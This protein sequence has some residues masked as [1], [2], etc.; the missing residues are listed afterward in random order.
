MSVVSLKRLK[1]PSEPFEKTE[2]SAL[3]PIADILNEDYKYMNK[4]S[5]LKPRSCKS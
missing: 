4:G 2:C 1:K 3:P 5:N